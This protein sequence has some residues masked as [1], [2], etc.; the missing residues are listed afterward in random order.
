MRACPPRRRSSAP[1]RGGMGS[2]PREAPPHLSRG[3]PQHK[4]PAKFV[5]QVALP[6]EEE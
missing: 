5:T 1:M 6:L 2:R 3:P 4:A